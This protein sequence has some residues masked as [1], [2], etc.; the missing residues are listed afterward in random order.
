MPQIQW[1]IF[2]AGSVELNRDLACRTDGDQVVYYS[3]Q[4][5]VFTH[6]RDDW[7]SFRMFTSQLIVQG[8]A[9]QGHI[10]KAFGVAL[11]TIK[12]G[13]DPGLAGVCDS[14]ARAE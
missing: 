3:G 14:N 9:T 8:T 13:R 6:R 2:P 1:P 10:A 5:P 11:V 7:G 4:L 12:R